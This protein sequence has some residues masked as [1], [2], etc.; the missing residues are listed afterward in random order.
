MRNQ[1]KILGR[2]PEKPLLSEKTLRQSLGD[3]A[4]A[5]KPWRQSLGNKDL[6][7]F[8]YRVL[9]YKDGFFFRVRPEPKSE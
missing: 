4:L 3:K 5:T 6:K 7:T 8:P 9:L 1:Q 2:E